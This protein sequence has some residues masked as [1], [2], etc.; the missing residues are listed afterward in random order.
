MTFDSDK[1]ILF[2]LFEK[3]KKV[4][5]F[6]RKDGGWH[7]H[8]ARRRQVAAWA[9]ASRAF[10]VFRRILDSAS[11]GLFFF[12]K[13]RKDFS[14]RSTRFVVLATLPQWEGKVPPGGLG[15]RR[16]WKK[17]LF[18]SE[19]SPVIT[20]GGT[21]QSAYLICCLLSSYWAIFSNSVTF[22]CCVLWRLR[23]SLLC[24]DSR[25]LRLIN[26]MN[27]SVVWDSRLTHLII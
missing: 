23:A 15:G 10:A 26:G 9:T 19:T 27:H 20:N 5:R 2:F 3:K 12:F 24:L 18:I 13:K 11:G 14:R 7:W 17:K 4:Y 22:G 8:S 6:P 1:R 21:S 16:K 25:T